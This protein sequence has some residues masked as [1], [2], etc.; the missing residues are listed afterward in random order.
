MTNRAVY[1]VRSK[2]S[3]FFSYT[4]TAFAVLSFYADPRGLDEMVGEMMGE[5]LEEDMETIFGEFDENMQIDSPFS[6]GAEEDER[7]QTDEFMDEFGGW[8]ENAVD[9]RKERENFDEDDLKDFAY[10]E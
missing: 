4:A 2:L 7:S 3:S 5:Q 6:K 8:E 1:W 9:P 10:D